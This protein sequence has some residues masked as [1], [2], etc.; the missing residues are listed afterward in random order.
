MPLS[1]PPPVPD[2]QK[3]CTVQL[4]QTLANLQS[5]SVHSQ[6]SGKPLKSSKSSPSFKQEK[7]SAAA[8]TDKQDPMA[9]QQMQALVMSLIPQHV[10]APTAMAM[11]IAGFSVSS[12]P[13]AQ[14]TV[15]MPPQ[16]TPVPLQ[17]MSPA[18][19][20]P[21]VVFYPVSQPGG[22]T[23]ANTNNPHKR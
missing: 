18:G 17:Y 11:P 5:L 20:A 1:P 13:T 16:M 8:V 2:A 21:M 23:Q 4:Q 14:S 10:M 7:Q 12:P 9:P 3:Q 22:P 6:P 19:Y 15:P